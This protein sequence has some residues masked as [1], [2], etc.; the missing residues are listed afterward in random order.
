MR[1]HHRNSAPFRELKSGVPLSRRG[2]AGVRG[3]E[4][5]FGFSDRV[6]TLAS[7]TVLMA[8]AA[9]RAAPPAAAPLAM[10]SGAALEHDPQGRVISVELGDLKPGDVRLAQ[11]AL[12][13]ALE[14]VT[15][16]NGALG[17]SDWARLAPLGQLRRLYVNRVPLDGPSLEAIGKLAQLEV[18]ALRQ[19]RVAG[20][21]LAHLA[22]LRQLRVLNLSQNPIDDASL[23]HIGR[24]TGLDTLGLQ[25]TQ[26]TGSGL[27]H[28][29]QLADL[30]VLNLAHCPVA[31][32]A[33]AYLEDHRQLRMLHIEHCQLTDVGVK[34]LHDQVPG[35]AIYR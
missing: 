26:I 12:L 15:L 13:P 5:T 2:K 3:G 11:L 28:L 6:F 21:G 33:L 17:P 20:P 19:T 8:A 10:I 9:L 23:A 25:D 18:L 29:R 22:G 27:G 7:L 30:R 16:S 35:L 1:T 34:R 32:W 4:K 24:L 31:D 14:T